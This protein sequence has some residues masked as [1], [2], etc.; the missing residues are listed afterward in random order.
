MKHIS[1][2]IILFAVL[3][4]SCNKREVESDNPGEKVEGFRPVYM[5]P[6]EAKDLSVKGAQPL[7]DPGKIYWYY[8]YVFLTDKGKGVHV[9]D[10]ADPSNPQKKAF[11]KIPGVNDVAVKSNFLY[12][13]NVSDLV[14]FN[15]NNMDA[16]T[17][18]DRIEDVYPVD[19]QM[20]PSG[21]TGYFECVDTTKGVV[22]D[23]QKVKLEDPKC[24]K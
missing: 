21:V 9:I 7:E 23:W 6:D 10:I 1:L 20:Y 2:F 11:I 15:I 13:D 18:T 16:I 3:L 19:Q 22:V 4:S 17:F 5:D 12:A 24:Q 8:N 14:I